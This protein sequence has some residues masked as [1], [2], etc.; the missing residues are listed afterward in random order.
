MSSIDSVKLTKQ[1][2]HETPLPWMS[3]ERQL[4]KL[5]CGKYVRAWGKWQWI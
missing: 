1:T 5:S 3:R 4:I 2:L